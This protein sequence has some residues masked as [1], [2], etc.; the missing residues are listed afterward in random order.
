[1]AIAIAVLAVAVVASVFTTSAAA[2]AKPAERTRTSTIATQTAAADAEMD[3]WTWFCLVHSDAEDFAACELGH[4][5]ASADAADLDPMTKFCLINKPA[6]EFKNCEAGVPAKAT[7]STAKLAAPDRA[8]GGDNV[9]GDLGYLC[10]AGTMAVPFD[11]PI[12]DKETG[13]FVVDTMVVWYCL[14]ADLEPAG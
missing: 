7:V 5:P 14:P 11:H 3:P 9:P 2:D 1:M 8:G 10:P 6:A 13:L 12:Y 4:V